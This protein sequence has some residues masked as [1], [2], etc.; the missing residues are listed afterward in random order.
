MCMVVSIAMMMVT[1]AAAIGTGFRF[2]WR[3]FFGNGC[4]Q[5]LQHLLQNRILMNPQE[6]VSHL[7]LRMPVTQMKGAAQQVVWRMAGNPV[8]GFSGSNNL[9]Y[10]SIF[11]L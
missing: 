9:Y 1:A 7:S 11:T 5:P 10:P 3:C 2:E 6:S 4:T 8:S